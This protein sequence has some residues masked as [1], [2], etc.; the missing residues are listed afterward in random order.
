LPD[1]ES[2]AV[3]EPTVVLRS[4]APVAP[5]PVAAERVSRPLVLALAVSAAVPS[6]IAPVL[7]VTVSAPLVLVRSERTT[8]F[9]A[10]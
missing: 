9:E 7:A 10:V 6:V 2:T 3:I 8:L 4:A 5:M 1:T